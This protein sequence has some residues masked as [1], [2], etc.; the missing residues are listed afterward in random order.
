MIPKIIEEEKDAFLNS[1]SILYNNHI[2]IPICDM[3]RNCAYIL[4]N[5]QLP[6]INTVADYCNDH[7]CKTCSELVS[8]TP[9]NPLAPSVTMSC[10]PSLEPI[11][12]T[13]TITAP[14]SLTISKLTM[15]TNN[16]IKK[17]IERVSKKK[18]PTKNWHNVASRNKM[19]AGLA[20]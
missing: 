16:N 12:Y 2:Y 5:N 7:E 19:I 13:I 6:K 10:K 1:G 4:L 20:Q 9:Y 18:I 11:K 15:P 14:N 3:H 8:S 17:I